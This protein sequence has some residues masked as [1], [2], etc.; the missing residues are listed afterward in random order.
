[1]SE[2][3][4]A[5]QVFRRPQSF[6]PADDSIVRSSARQLRQKLGE[7]YLNAGRDETLLVEIPKGAY[8][9]VFTVRQPAPLVQELPTGAPADVPAQPTTTWRRKALLGAVCIAALA[10][11]LW[12]ALPR[13]SAR[14]AQS[15]PTLL[16]WL[17]S[18]SQGSF[19]V[20]LPDSALNI[21]NSQRPKI[22]TLDE[23]LRVEEQ[24]S[25]I[26]T[27][28]R[29]VLF[30]ERLRNIAA[31]NN[32]RVELR[33][34]R[35]MQLRDFR[36]G[37][38][39]VLG[40]SWSNPWASLFHDRLNFR[41]EQH[42]DGT[43]G[44]RNLAPRSGERDF[45]TSTPKEARDGV[46][47]AT[48]SVN[49]NLSGSGLVVVAA[50]IRS[51]GNEGKFDALSSE[52][53]FRSLPQSVRNLRPRDALGLELLLQIDAKAGVAHHTRLL[54]LRPPGAANRR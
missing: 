37:H 13:E 45:Y 50:G 11:A 35:L 22:L 9:P 3:E 43:Y 14:P 6:N 27:S 32:T 52:E 49:P 51:E 2:Y 42:A 41:F 48:I 16:S 26:I 29:D 18:E 1:M 46:S 28:Y 12:A 17:F 5:F 47:Y 39:L 54:A 20:V 36:E 53:L 38:Y 21:V 25:R 4:I 30:L 8:V 24:T 7:Y 33:H 19:A 23:Y 40:D 31:Q 10:L 44:I 34:S 15:E